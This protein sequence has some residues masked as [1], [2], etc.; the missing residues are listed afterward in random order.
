MRIHEN[1]ARAFLL[2]C[3]DEAVLAY[4]DFVAVCQIFEQLPHL[5]TALLFE[6]L[7]IVEILPLFQ[8][9]FSEKICN[10]IEILVED[11]YIDQLDKI[12]C[13]VRRLLID[14]KQWNVCVIESAGMLSTQ[15]I[16]RLAEIIESYCTGKVEFEFS[17]NAQLKAGYRVFLNETVLD[18]SVAGR[19]AT[20][21]TEVE[22]G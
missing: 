22:H 15:T 9:M 21:L 4:E 2:A 6:P 18:L 1:Y 16:K 12:K 5:S 14:K 20:L 8:E 11:G 19:L 17:V 3:H 13:Q 7:R 10:F